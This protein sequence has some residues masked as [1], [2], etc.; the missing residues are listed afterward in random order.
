MKNFFDYVREDLGATIPEGN[1]PSNWFWENDL[2]MIVQCHCCGMTM[3]SP[4]AWVDEETYTYC[5]DCAGVSN[6]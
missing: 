5:P 2:P 3:S 1:I 4:S 6:S